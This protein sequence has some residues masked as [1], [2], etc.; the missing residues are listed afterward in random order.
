[1]PEI[2]NIAVLQDFTC[3]AGLAMFLGLLGYKW[4]RL[5]RPEAAWNHEGLVTSQQY[6]DIDLVAL[7]AGLGLLLS[8]IMQ[9][10]SQVA[11]TP[12]TTPGVNEVALGIF[13]QLMLCCVLLVY[14][15]HVRH[16]H[17]VELF[18]FTV[19]RWKL[20]AV[21]ILLALIP[22]FV[23]VGTTAVLS[24]EWLQQL[25][26]GAQEQELV[27][28]FV[29]TDDTVLRVLI[30]LA[31]VVVAPVVEETLF[32][33]FIYGVLKRYTDAPFAA[34]LSGLFFAIIHMHTGSLLP[35]WV[36]ALFFCAAYEFTG[37][38]LA[39]MILHALFNST[40]IVGMMMGWNATP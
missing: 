9:P 17:P 13:F 10:L 14:L 27:R 6:G 22:M 26:P 1:M 39:P 21:T 25:A 5:M 11:A 34:L 33:G 18:G 2:A 4:L 31:A 38:L 19:V 8:A 37:C 30:I 16:L 35:L 40:S 36:L 7:A 29:E 15:S 32:R 20:L 28:A 12:Q 3:I 24:N 23:V